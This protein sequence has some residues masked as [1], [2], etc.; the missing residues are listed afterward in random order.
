MPPMISPISTSGL[1]RLKRL[2]RSKPG[3]RLVG[4]LALEGGEQHQRRE[5]GGADRVALGHRLGRVAD[6]VERIGDVAH[7]LGQLRHLGDAAGVVGDRPEGVEGDDQAAE[8]ELRHHGD[9]DAVDAG[10]LVGAED[11]QGE[12]Q[13]RS[14]G[15]LEA[16]GE[17]LDDVR[18][19]PGL[20]CLGDRLHRPEAGRRIKFGDHEQ[21]RGHGDADHRAEP[22]VGDADRVGARCSRRRAAAGRSSASR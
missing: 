14:G 6:R 2:L 22:E 13:R 17:P 3:R 9:A 7:V 12:H 15:R 1:V 19:V 18:R 11:R 4:Q 10:Q 5:R 16:L 8:R 20:R 21:Q